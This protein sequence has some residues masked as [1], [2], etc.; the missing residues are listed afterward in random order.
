M[1]EEVNKKEYNR[2]INMSFC[3][4]TKQNKINML[5]PKGHGQNILSHTHRLI[6]R[7]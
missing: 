5:I 4:D 2:S 3:D 6:E 7:L 1:L